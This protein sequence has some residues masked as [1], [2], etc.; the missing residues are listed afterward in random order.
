MVVVNEIEFEYFSIF[1]MSTNLL[2]KPLPAVKH[3]WYADVRIEE[4]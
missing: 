3:T 1:D 4:I 2:T